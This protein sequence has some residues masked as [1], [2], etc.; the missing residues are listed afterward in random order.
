MLEIILIISVQ[1]SLKKNVILRHSIAQGVPAMI[2]SDGQRIKQILINL[3]RNAIKFTLKGYIEAVL[4][5]S[6]LV[7]IVNG[8]L[9]GY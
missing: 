9:Y 4:K 3:L 8:Q 5:S 1:M 2:E 6:N 7:V